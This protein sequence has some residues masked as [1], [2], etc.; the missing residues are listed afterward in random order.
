MIYDQNQLI[1]SIDIHNINVAHGTGKIG[2]WLSQHA[3]GQG[4]ATKTVKF[5]CDIAFNDLLL[6]RLEICAQKENS[7]SQRVAEKAGFRFMGEARDEVYRRGQYVTMYHYELLKKDF[8]K[9]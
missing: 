3:T 8:K 1:G 4:V 7:A 9:R 2:Y 6:N 5:L